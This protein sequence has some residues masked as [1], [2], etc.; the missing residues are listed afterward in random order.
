MVRTRNHPSP[1]DGEGCD[2]NQKCPPR[3]ASGLLPA[4]KNTRRGVPGADYFDASTWA[5]VSFLRGTAV[6]LMSSG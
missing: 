4:E 6:A 1:I 3:R 2:E 5:L